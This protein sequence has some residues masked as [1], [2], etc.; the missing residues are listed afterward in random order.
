M[1]ELAKK[2]VIL[3]KTLNY[4]LIFVIVSINQA[5]SYFLQLIWKFDPLYYLG[6]TFIISLSASLVIKNLKLVLPL[7]II[8]LIVG[9]P[10]SFV[11]MIIPHL[12]QGETEILGMLWQIHLV[13]LA[14]LFFLGIPVSLIGG[15]IGGLAS[16]EA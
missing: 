7:I 6:L 10:L 4:T 2:A 1:T 11:L 13:A 14:K 15:L 9:I 8:S 3:K 5:S 16:G 12:V